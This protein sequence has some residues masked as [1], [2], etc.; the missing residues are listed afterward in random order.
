M[1]SEPS[2]FN[3]GTCQLWQGQLLGHAKGNTQPCLACPQEQW[4]SPDRRW[5]PRKAFKFRSAEG[6][7]PGGYSMYM[8]GGPGECRG[9]CSSR[10]TCE[11]HLS[12]PSV[13]WAAVWLCQTPSLPWGWSRCAGAGLDLEC[14]SQ[15]EAVKMNNGSASWKTACG[16]RDF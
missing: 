9:S 14:S 1:C 6:T 3:T 10:R 5:H 8:C 13:Q 11:V 16:V 7:G 4:A 2:P 12:H 15:L